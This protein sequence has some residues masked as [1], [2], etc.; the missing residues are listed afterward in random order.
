MWLQ[1]SCQRSILNLTK[2]RF[3]V[4][5][6]N[7][8][9]FILLKLSLQ[10]QMGP[11]DKEDGN[12]KPWEHWRHKNAQHRHS[13]SV[14]LHTAAQFGFKVHRAYFS[15]KNKS[16][17]PE[18]KFFISWKNGDINFWKRQREL[19]VLSAM[20]WSPNPVKISFLVSISH[21]VIKA[22]TFE[23]SKN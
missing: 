22:L 5:S 23:Y 10:W 9:F 6:N 14:L 8:S 20:I 15:Q 7:L 16:H 17:C 3:E 21:K 4:L 1:C 18:E 13:I 12:R 19:A 11:S 2:E